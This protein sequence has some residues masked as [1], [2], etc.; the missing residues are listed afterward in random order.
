MF[1]ILNPSLDI[2]GVLVSTAILVKLTLDKFAKCTSQLAISVP[3][4]PFIFKFLLIAANTTVNPSTAT[5][6]TNAL[7]IF[8]LLPFSMLLLLISIL[9]VN[10]NKT[11]PSGQV[12]H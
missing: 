8:T 1:S 11:P 5:I 4:I 9:H 12:F 6:I 3:A 10:N 2:L 7:I